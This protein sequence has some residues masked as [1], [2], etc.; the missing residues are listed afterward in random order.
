MEAETAKLEPE[1][2]EPAETNQAEEEV[3]DLESKVAQ[4]T[5]SAEAPPVNQEIENFIDQMEAPTPLEQL[6][7]DYAE[8]QPSDSEDEISAQTAIPVLGDVPILKDVPI[9]GAVSTARQSQRFSNHTPVRPI[10]R[11]TEVKEDDAQEQTKKIIK[12][13]VGVCVG[14]VVLMCLCCGVF[15]QAGG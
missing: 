5:D 15:S 14:I 2:V 11:P 12:I 7:E 10:R 13:T 6:A 4:P 8:A 3:I 9:R 1:P